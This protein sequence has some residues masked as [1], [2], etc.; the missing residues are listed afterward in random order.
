MR[1]L[2]DR[3]SVETALEAANVALQGKR[4][5]DTRRLTSIELRQVDSHRAVWEIAL[6]ACAGVV[7]FAVLFTL[8]LH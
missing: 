3:T 7:T 5:R 2:V 4:A 1:A 8:L 6:A